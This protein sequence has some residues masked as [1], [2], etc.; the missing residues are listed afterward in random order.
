MTEEHLSTLEAIRDALRRCHAGQPQ[1][2]LY[3]HHALV[4]LGQRGILTT[5]LE[6]ML[7]AQGEIV[8]SRASSTSPSCT[9]LLWDDTGRPLHVH[10]AYV[11][12]IIVTVFEADDPS[13]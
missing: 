8:E 13:Q 11:R 7:L 9:I 3:S 6:Q 1:P 5:D 4:R 2:L 10:I 12:M